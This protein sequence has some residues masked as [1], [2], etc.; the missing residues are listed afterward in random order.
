MQ[1]LMTAFNNPNA[2][3]VS[4]VRGDEALC[5]KEIITSALQRRITKQLAAQ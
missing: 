1:K 2:P 3:G 4:V 5:G